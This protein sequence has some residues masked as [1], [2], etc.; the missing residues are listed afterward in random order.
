MSEL[1]ESQA[2]RMKRDTE[3]Q[4]AMNKDQSEPELDDSIENLSERNSS[5]K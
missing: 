2:G 5:K 1:G 4:P 3:A